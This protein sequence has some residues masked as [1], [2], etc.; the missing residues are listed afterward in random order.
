MIKVNF[1]AEVDEARAQ[2][3]LAEIKKDKMG[4]WMELPRKYDMGEFAR[5]KEAAKK[6]NEESEY[7]VCIGIGGSYLGHRAV[8]EALRP[9]SETKIIYAGNSLSRR[10]L[11]WALA[12]VG[13]HDFS[14]NVISKSGTTLEPAIAFEAFKKKLV[15]KY[16]AE[17]ATRRIYAT[18]DAKQGALH[19]EATENGYTKFVVPDNIG[20]R[21]SVLTAVGLLPMAVAGVDVDKMLKG[22]A[23]AV[24]TAVEPA[25]NYAFMRYA[26]DAKKYDTEIFASFEPSTV[27]FNEWLK[28]LFGESEGKDKRGILPDSVIYS[29]DLHSLGQYLQDGRRN[30][31]ETIID[32]PTDDLNAKIVAAVRIAHTGGGIPVLNIS[33]TSFDEKGFGELIYFF[34]LACAVSAKL[35]G[36]NPFDQPGVEKYKLELHKLLG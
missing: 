1:N 12:K 23:E 29:T 14:I 21:Y 18:T 9:K 36:V 22:A 4:G 2:K 13:D 30:L 6:I 3:I 27:Y 31:F 20:G 16:G 5:I 11:E 35:I 10:E 15:E 8:I 26:L 17:E 19:D 7:L 28:Q 33:V 32:F 25:L 34:E 24:E